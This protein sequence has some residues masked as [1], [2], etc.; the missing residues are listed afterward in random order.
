[1][2]GGGGLPAVPRARLHGLHVLPVQHH[3]ARNRGV[4]GASLRVL[5]PRLFQVRAVGRY[6]SATTESDLRGVTV[7]PRA[8]I[9]F[10]DQPA[11][12]HTVKVGTNC[13]P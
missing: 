3:P 7:M 1:M 8:K 11:V 13:S 5:H 6:A 4:A 2:H 10:D 9:V 12:R